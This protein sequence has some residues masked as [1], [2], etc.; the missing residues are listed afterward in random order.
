MSPILL[1]GTSISDSAETVESL[2]NPLEENSDDVADAEVIVEQMVKIM[3]SSGWS[4]DQM[5]G[6]I[7]QVQS[8]NQK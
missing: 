6:V 8:G 7:S 5:L 3:A 4:E 1:K 2:V